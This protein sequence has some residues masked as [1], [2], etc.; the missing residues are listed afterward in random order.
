MSVG[1][2]AEAV[3]RHIL[4]LD[5]EVS[6]RS[7]TSMLLRRRGYRV[8]EAD[9]GR[10]GL[11][12]FLADPSAVAAMLVDLTMPEMDGAAFLGALHGHQPA[13]PVIA[14]SG[15]EWIEARE[16]LGGMPLAGYLQKPFTPDQLFAAVAAVTASLPPS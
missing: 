15:H 9:N 2:A 3:E 14:M 7:V 4:L 16:R 8:I 10:D 6:V 1:Q 5:D 13:P 11:S 12:R